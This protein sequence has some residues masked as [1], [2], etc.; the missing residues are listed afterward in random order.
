MIL[1]DLW[2]KR[3]KDWW[4]NYLENLS[5]YFD[6]TFYDCTELAQIDVAIFDEKVLH[7]HFV[8]GGIDRAVQKLINLEKEEIEILAFS[9]GGVIAW[10]YALRTSNVNS[11]YAVSSTRLRKERIKPN[12]EIHLCYG[13]KDMHI[14]N[15]SWFDEIKIKPCILDLMGHEMYKDKSF[16]HQFCK[17]LLNN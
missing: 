8:K 11:L 14:P 16:A 6:V 13:A 17:Q 7:E 1:S 4:R 5:I 15:A 3:K 9:I 2:G 12:G 10:Q